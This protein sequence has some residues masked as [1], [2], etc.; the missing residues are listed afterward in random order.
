MPQN[1][2]EYALILNIAAVVIISTYALS[3]CFSKLASLLYLSRS[4]SDSYDLIVILLKGSAVCI[5]TQI[6]HDICKDSGQTAVASA[7]ILA[8]R[9]T[10]VALTLPLIESVLK[11]AIAYIN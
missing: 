1:K 3:T 9:L 10:V 7:V 2:K 5:F 4:L 11:T 6:V 8:G